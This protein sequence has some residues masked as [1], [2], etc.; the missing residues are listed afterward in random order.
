MRWS[1]GD[2]GDA[3]AAQ[4]EATQHVEGLGTGRGAVDLVLGA[5][6]PAQVARDGR[7]HGGIV[8]NRQDRRLGHTSSVL[9]GSA[10]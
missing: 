2:Q 7:R 8:V 4:R 1:D 6:L 9:V 10:R 5:V 3:A